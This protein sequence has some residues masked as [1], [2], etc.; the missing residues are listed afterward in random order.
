MTKWITVLADTPEEP[1]SAP[2][3]NM[4]AEKNNGTQEHV[5]TNTTEVCTNI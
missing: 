5:G 4:V 1:S 2:A 3:T